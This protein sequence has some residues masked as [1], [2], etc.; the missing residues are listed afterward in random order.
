MAEA[1][2]LVDE[3]GHDRLTLA[4]IADRV[5]VAVPSLYKH[6]AGIEDLQRRLAVRAV[7]ELGDALTAAAVGRSR[8]E[9]LH[10]LA[11]AYRAF[12]RR[13]PGRYSATLRAPDPAD[14][15]HLEATQAV[16][17]TVLAVLAGYGLTG[18][19]AIHAARAVRSA[20]H[21]FVTLEVVGGFGLPPDVDR[22]YARLVDAL[23]HALD[24]W[25]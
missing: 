18:D 24:T 7:R 19:D 9:A 17:D 6:V 13:H 25:T 3:V 5:G 22:S 4:G 14:A 20:L 1:A 11:D 8:S 15:D 23:D 16:L 10:G 2:A 12:C 21:G